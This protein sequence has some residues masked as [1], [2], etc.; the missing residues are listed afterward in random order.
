VD[1]GARGRDDGRSHA[2]REER[3]QA[4]GHDDDQAPHH[5]HDHHDA[6]RR[7]WSRLL[8]ASLLTRRRDRRG[9]DILLSKK[10]E[11]TGVSS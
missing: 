8:M 4:P 6:R 2:F 9:L 5:D 1:A 11:T 3:S 7:G 10:R